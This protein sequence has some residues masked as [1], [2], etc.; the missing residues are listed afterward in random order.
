MRKIYAALLALT[1]GA[2][3]AD[4]RRW[5]HNH[6]RLLVEDTDELARDRAPGE[7]GAPRR[8]GDEDDVTR[9]LP[10]GWQLQPTDPNWKGRRYISADGFAKIAIFSSEVSEQS[11]TAQM[12]DIAFGEGEQISYLRGERDWVVASGSKDNHVFYR[13]ASLACG[14]KSWHRIEF[15]YPFEDKKKLDNL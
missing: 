14:G 13:K 4:A 15:E 6:H 7:P 10:R 1:L 8:Q 12:R 3:A 5:H 11:V 9:W 2:T